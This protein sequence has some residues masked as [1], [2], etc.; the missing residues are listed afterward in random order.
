MNTTHRFKYFLSHKLT[1]NG[2]KSYEQF[3]KKHPKHAMNLSIGNYSNTQVSRFGNLSIDHASR[4]KNCPKVV[5]ACKRIKYLP[6]LHLKK[7]YI[8]TNLMKPYVIKIVKHL[9][10]LKRLSS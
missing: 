8:R 9:K 3:F 1:V 7:S 4:N 5:R 10:N 2:S 6:H